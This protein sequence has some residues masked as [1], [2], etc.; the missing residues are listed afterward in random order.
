M[1][2]LFI[3]DIVGKPGR[4]AVRLLLPRLREQYNP[5]VV[6]ANGENMAGGN[7]ITRETAEEMLRLGIALLTTGNHVW[8]H[9]EVLDYMAGNPPVLRPLNYPPGVPGWGWMEVSVDGADLIVVCLQGRVFMRALDD[10]F[11]AIDGLLEELAGK[12]NIVVDFHAEA[13][14]EKQALGFY[15]DGRVS[16][17]LGTHTHVP[18]ADARVL[19]LGTAYMTDVG[20]VGPRDSVIGLDPDAVIKRH[21]TQM[22]HRYEVA[23]GP[24]VLGAVV[25][26]IDP[27]TGHATGICPVHE[28]LETR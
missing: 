4:K 15:L 7:G 14:A 26:D 16:A 12:R 20:M 25:V 6:I 28:L 18:T 1:R 10:P 22:F 19:P 5:D 8:D 13:S 2:V 23:G 17:V 11:R 24:V 27:A 9:R 3:G 21:L